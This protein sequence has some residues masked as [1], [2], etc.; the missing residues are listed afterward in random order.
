[1]MPVSFVKKV[2]YQQNLHIWNQRWTTT[3]KGEITRKFFPTVY[4]R[5]QSRRFFATDFYLTQIL[6]NHGKLN[7]YLTRF[8]V[9]DN[10]LCLVCKTKKD[11]MHV[12]FHCLKYDKQ[13]EDLIQHVLQNN[14]SWPCNLK[15]LIS[16]NIFI[17]FKR[18]CDTTIAEALLLY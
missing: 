8:K 7:S 6:S 11:V 3:T 16:T 10:E 2:V 1:M 5:L 17:E 18:F 13:R 15:N 12:I 4:K 14:I 9:T